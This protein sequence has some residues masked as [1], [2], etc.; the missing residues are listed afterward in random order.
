MKI[1]FKQNVNP[2]LVEFTA[3]F[4][5]QQSYIDILQKCNYRFGLN[6]LNKDEREIPL[7]KSSYIKLSNRT[8]ASAIGKDAKL[9]ISELIYSRPLSVILCIVKLKDKTKDSHIILACKSDFPNQLIEGLIDGTH[10]N[11]GGYYRT[12]LEN[13]ILHGKIGVKLKV[14]DIENDHNH[15]QSQS[16]SQSQDDQNHRTSKVYNRQPP[17]RQTFKIFD[18]DHKLSKS[19]QVPDQNLSKSSI[20]SLEKLKKKYFMEENKLASKLQSKHGLNA[21]VSIT[22]KLIRPEVAESVERL[23]YRNKQPTN[24]E[25][26]GPE[27]HQGCIVK[28]GPRGGKY[29][30]KGSKKIYITSGTSD[31]KNKPIY[32]VRILRSGEQ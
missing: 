31:E 18:P 5:H 4:V 19:N 1:C 26:D 32:K 27:M 17:K 10:E 2:E 14:D 11:F 22:H 13:F 25:S 20:S 9:T 29:I 8:L 15:S 21:D 16:Q 12:K 24:A 23:P 7:V 3:L 6:L 28:K 30:M